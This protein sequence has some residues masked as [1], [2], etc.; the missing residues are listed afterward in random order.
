MISSVSIQKLMAL[1]PIVFLVACATAEKSQPVAEKRDWTPSPQSA[2]GPNLVGDGSSANIDYDAIQRNL[3]LERNPDELGYQ[4]KSFNT[5]QIGYGYS[6]S[7][8]CQNRVFVV[9]HFQLLCRDSVGTV[10]TIVR[11][12]DMQA[13]SNKN[14]NWKLK[15]KT[16]SLLTDSAG[17]GQIRMIASESQKSQRLKLGVENDFLYMR[18]QEINR[19]V[20]P[21][22]WC[23]P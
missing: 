6:N 7:N 21:Q 16:G 19:V 23:S 13:I 11:A 22:N 18:A 12:S 9:I 20:T 10:S 2:P 5:C 4:E 17:Y 3:G 14:V 8:D 15:N 1:F